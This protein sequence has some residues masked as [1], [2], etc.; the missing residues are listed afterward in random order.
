ML[1]DDKPEVIGA[2]VPVWEHVIFDKSYNKHI[3]GQRRINW[4]NYEEVLTE[5]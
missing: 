5:L 4:Q 3:N 2:G 1:I